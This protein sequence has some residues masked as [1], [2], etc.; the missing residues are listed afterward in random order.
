MKV[1][2]STCRQRACSPAFTIVEL[3]VAI[4][5]T[6]L[7]V[8]LMLTIT[9]NMLSGWNRSSGV[10]NT[11][12]QARYIL[13]QLSLDLQSAVLPTGTNAVFAVTI[14]RNQT[15][16]GDADATEAD[17]DGNIKPGIAGATDTDDS[18][19]V[20]GSNEEER[21]IALYRFG[22]AGVWLRF[23][24]SVSDGATADLE[25]AS[26]P[27][28][29]SYQIVRRR[30]TSDADA[31][32]VYQLFR[33]EVRP[34][35]DA[36]T[37]R[38]RSTFGVGYDLLGD[39]AYNDLTGDTGADEDPSR[40]RKPNLASLIGEGVVDFGVRVFVYQSGSLVE[41]FPVNRRVSDTSLVE[42]FV[43]SSDVT[44][45]AAY[46][47]D[48][49]NPADTDTSYGY[50]AV[51]EVMIRV[52]TPQGIQTI[53]AFEEDPSRYGGY[54]AAKWWELAEQNSNVYVRRI[55]IISQQK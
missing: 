14:Q 53:Q 4:G 9:L 26:A 20:N 47:T 27:R 12:N 24:S 1:S 55:S 16:D 49:G 39:N 35:G 38:A 17:W 52:L 3:L 21:D 31:S 28:A 30:R 46:A 44:K 43:A 18:F 22:Q 25:N 51:L 5:V 37:E 15:G 34:Y 33:S 11:G 23:I 29:V 54:S 36:A 19:H 2:M 45:E 48:A 10:L 6:A 41:A 50:P 7:M 42:S 40:I 13:D 8:I 32:Y